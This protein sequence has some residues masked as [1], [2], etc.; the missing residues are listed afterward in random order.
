M[1]TR[2][3]PTEYVEETL[4]RGIIEGVHP[5]HSSL[6]AE[7]ELAA[8]LGVTRPTVREALQRLSRD[9]WITIQHGK[10]TRINDIW[11]EGGLNILSGLIRYSQALPDDFVANLLAIR[12]D[13]A[14]SYARA[15]VQHNP[16]MVR[17]YVR[18][19]VSLEDTAQAFA[20]FDWQLHRVLTIAS[21]NPIY[22]LILNGF[23]GFYETMARLY[24]Y[25]AQ[26]RAA[27]REFYQVLHEAA[28]QGNAIAAETATLAAI[29][30]SLHYWEQVTH[31]SAQNT[32]EE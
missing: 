11:R 21:D 19:W 1:S 32:R 24:F 13:L 7:R 18:T 12:L 17:E 6:P 2:Q 9:G 8:Q 29:G 5:A 20:S 22:T 15:A 10:S 25:P 27:S 4:M 28:Q 16:F 23:G 26:A 31:A 30:A 14:P 3:K